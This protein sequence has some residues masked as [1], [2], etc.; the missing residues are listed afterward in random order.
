[1]RREFSVSDDG[2]QI[3][4]RRPKPRTT[5]PREDVFRAGHYKVLTETGNLRKKSLW[6]V[7]IRLGNTII[8]KTPYIAGLFNSFVNGLFLI[9]T[10]LL[11]SLYKNSII[12]VKLTP[13]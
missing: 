4:G 3:F 10:I 2:R 8:Y 9:L 13:N 7:V 12:D 11:F 1:M 6:A 5:K